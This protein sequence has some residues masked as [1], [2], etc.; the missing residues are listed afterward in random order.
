MLLH[1]LPNPLNLLKQITQS[2]QK[3]KVD[4]QIT[5]L[6]MQ[7]FEKTLYKEGIVLSRPDKQRLLR[8]VTKTVLT[9]MLAKLDSAEKK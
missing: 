8:Q 2:V 6:I 1:E 4:D 3:A 7:T 5:E 9:D